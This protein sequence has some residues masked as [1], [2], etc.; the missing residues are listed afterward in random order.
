MM[1][2]RD[3]Y[4][5]LLELA[6]PWTVKAVAFNEGVKTVDVYLAHAA[7]AEFACPRCARR[8]NACCDSPERTWRHLDTCGRT[9]LLHAR[10]P[11]VH[12]PDHGKLPVKPPWGDWESCGTP[13]FERSVAR[14]AK[15]FG[16]I[17][18]AA[19]FVRAERS[20]VRNILRSA[21]EE[22]GKAKDGP[23][24]EPESAAPTTAAPEARQLSLFAQDDMTFVNQGIKAFRRL[25]LEKAAEL[26]QKHRDIYP[27]GYDVGP[28]LSAAEFLLVG[29]REAP[30][31]PCARTA[32]LCRLWDSFENRAQ[33]EETAWNHCAAEVK[34]AFFSLVAEES[35]RSGPT[36][37]A[38]LPG[39]IPCGFI[40]L[41]AERVE[42][43]I[44]SLQNS[45]L[46]TPDNPALY[47]WL[48]DAYHL[49]GDLRVARQC[50][51]E[52]CL[53]DPLGIDWRHLRDEDLRELERELLFIYG[54]DENLARAWLPS[55]ARVE[56]LFE[57][58]TVRLHDGLKEVVDGYLAL[59]KALLKEKSPLVQAKLFFRGLVLCENEESLK[60]VKKIDPVEVR[61][62]MK[63]A[64]PDLFSEFLAQ[65][66]EGDGAGGSRRR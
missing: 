53:I 16:D 43:A 27:K 60:Y 55:H 29:M 31:E 58:K 24:E 20:D 17:R 54:P 12:C 18:Q 30:A 2:L 14:L 61:R 15:G 1:D 13:A 19:L 21:A 41:Q 65:I 45:I 56:G 63:E 48:G 66:V 5:R 64:N 7:T 11:V 4:T 42:D 8:L 32:W 46:Q 3:F 36:D 35:E 28:R 49:R 62:F 9:T 6:S 38:F 22:P 59:E 50:Y 23:A 44:P 52:A 47:G 10:L 40:L 37:S 26:F 51:M 39:D 25:D 33:S 34:K 57:R